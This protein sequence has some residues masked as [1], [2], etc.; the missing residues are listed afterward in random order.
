MH[1]Y[2]VHCYQVKDLTVLHNY[3]SQGGHLS[4]GW[5]RYSYSSAAA[6]VGLYSFYVLSTFFLRGKDRKERYIGKDWKVGRSSREVVPLKFWDY[7][8]YSVPRGT[9]WELVPLKPADD[10]RDNIP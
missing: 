9:T 4:L 2:F 1:A 5:W 6:S 10:Y 7:W 3:L 8:T